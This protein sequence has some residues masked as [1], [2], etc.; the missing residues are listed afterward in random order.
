LLACWRPHWRSRTT[1]DYRI[2]PNGPVPPPR[3]IIIVAAIL[4]GLTM[5]IGA[6]TFVYAKGYSYLTNDPAACANC[7]IMRDHYN[8]WTRASH[9]SVAVCNDCHTPPGLV[10]KYLTKAQNGF[11][12]SFYFTTG[13]YPDPL[14]ITPRNHEVTELACR[15]CHGEITASIDPAHTST[16]RGGLTCTKCHN[17]VGHIE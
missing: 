8:A 4:A 15:K 11:W 3:L 16:G 6:Y 1:P 14:Q 2:H 12:H 5:G 9:R 7:H 10:P 17:D 13:R